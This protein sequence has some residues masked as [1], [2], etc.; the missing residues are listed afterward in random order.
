MQKT[1]IDRT[2]AAVELLVEACR[3]VESRGSLPA[4]VTLARA[5]AQAFSDRVQRTGDTSALWEIAKLTEKAFG[6]AFGWK[7]LQGQVLTPSNALKHGQDAAEAETVELFYELAVLLI[8]A[9]CCDCEKLVGS[10][11]PHLMAFRDRQM[12]NIHG[13]MTPAALHRAHADRPQVQAHMA[14]WRER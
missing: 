7:W 11:D 13:W 1:K 6:P 2:T 10:V 8:F 5:G 14:A 4:A 9:G 12:P 3:L